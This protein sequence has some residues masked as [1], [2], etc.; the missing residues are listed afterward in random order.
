MLYNKVAI[1]GACIT[2][3]STSISPA[4]AAN[5]EGVSFL[6]ISCCLPKKTKPKAKEKPQQRKHQNISIQPDHFDYF[7]DSSNIDISACTF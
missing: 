6:Q 7:I 5:K 4:P 3:A 1:I 2:L